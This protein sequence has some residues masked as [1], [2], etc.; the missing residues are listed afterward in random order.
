MRASEHTGN[1][2]ILFALNK[3]TDSEPWGFMLGRIRIIH[4]RCASFL[5]GMNYSGFALVNSRLFVPPRRFA[6]FLKTSL[7]LEVAL[8]I[9][10]SLFSEN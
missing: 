1:E 7:R 8:S 10:H 6:N 3:L 9:R 4:R 2:Y 5:S